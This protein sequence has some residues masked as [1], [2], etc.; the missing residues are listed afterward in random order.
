MKKTQH[1]AVEQIKL[2]RW[3]EFF[4]CKYP[5]LKMLYHIP[6]GGSRNKIEAANLKKQGVKSGVS[7]ICLPVPS[8]KYHGLYIEM[9]YGKNTPTDNQTKWLKN[10]SEQGYAIK[11]CYNW[12][13]AAKVICRYLG[14]PYT[15]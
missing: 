6:N 4:S 10:L 14:I 3:A 5:V 12:E 15:R 7:D 8:G 11:V 13:D 2:F 1:E 9:K